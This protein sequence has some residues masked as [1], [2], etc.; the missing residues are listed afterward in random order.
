MV[1][2]GGCFGNM[3]GFFKCS[4][5]VNGALLDHLSDVFDPV[6]LVLN[7]GCLLSA[8]NHCQEGKACQKILSLNS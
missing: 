2:G 7:A 8:V 6:L 5:Q 1:L 3:N 4:S